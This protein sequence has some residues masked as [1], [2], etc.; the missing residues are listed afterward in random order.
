MDIKALYIIPFSLFI[1]IEQL[2][3]CS[4]LLLDLHPAKVA[5]KLFPMLKNIP[6]CLRHV[7]TQK[8]NNY[9]IVLY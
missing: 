8:Q 1:L 2:L 3:C 5:Y 4:V 9:W 7:L 6:I